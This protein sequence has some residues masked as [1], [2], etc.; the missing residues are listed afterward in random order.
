M[1]ERHKN[2]EKYFKE[3]VF[4]TQKYVIPYIME[5]LSVDADTKVLEIG[6]GEGGNL[7]PFLDIG[8]TVTGVDILPHK[9]ENGKI[10][11]QSHPK[12]NNLTL[13]I[14]DIYDISNQ[15]DFTF[16]LI[17]MRDTIEH[18]P[19]QEKFMHHVRHFLK[20]GGKIFFAFPPWRMPFGGHQQICQNKFLSMLPYFHILPAFMY[21]GILRLFGESE[22][23]IED[24]AEIKDT[25][26][27]VSRFH[28]ILRKNGFGIEKETCYFINP[29]YEI[30]FGLKPRVL[31][32][33][34]KIPFFMDFYTTA[35]YCVVRVC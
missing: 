13:I 25:R 21:K 27:S 23:T 19:D 32:P 7:Q 1:Q 4:T 26:L 30:K 28:N 35:V 17:I 18:I 31:F 15:T 5:V 16:D 3:Q 9:I 14:K 33:W 29:N 11:Y 8:C 10:Y 22:Q 24:L 2:R 12:K 20:P 34:L 6:C